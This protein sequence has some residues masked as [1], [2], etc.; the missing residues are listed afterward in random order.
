MIKNLSLLL[1]LVVPMWVLAKQPTR[2]PQDRER[3]WQLY[4]DNCW[5]CHGQ[6]GGGRGPLS[7]ALKTPP[8][9]IAKRFDSSEFPDQVRVIM[10]GKGDMPGYSQ[11]MNRAGARQILNWLTDPKPMKSKAKSKSKSKGKFR[12]K[13]KS[14]FQPV[15]PAKF[16]L[17]EAEVDSKVEQDN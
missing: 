4:K 12:G 9:N 16:G 7:V 3:G 15:A 17:D 13:R 11:V 6:R 5:Q 2:R 1:L 14:K 8:P 10:R